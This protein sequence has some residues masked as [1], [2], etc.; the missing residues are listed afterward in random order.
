MTSFLNMFNTCLGL[1]MGLLY[2]Y[3]MIYV[4]IGLFQRRKPI[5]PSA[6][7]SAPLH[8]Y[9]V[10]IP[11]R[12]ERRVVPHLIDSLRRQDYPAELID[13]FV[14]ADNCTDD[15][16]KVARAAGA[17]VF[18]RQESTL[19]GKGY[20]LDYAMKEI[21]A[22]HDQGYDAF[23]VFDADNLV[24]HRFFT[25]INRTF[26]AGARIITSYRNSKNF[27][28]SWVSSASALWYLRESRFLNAV[29]RRLNSSCMISGTGFVVARDILERDNGW[30]YHL[31][32]EDI[33]FSIDSVIHGEKIVFCEEAMLYDE[34]PITFHQA[35]LQRLR[36]AKG[37]YQVFRHY[38]GA[39]AKR[40][41]SCPRKEKLSCFD[42]LMMILPAMLA[43]VLCLGM[44]LLAMIGGILISDASLLTAAARM[45]LTTFGNFYL[46]FVVYGLLTMITERNV[47][48]AT[49]Y[50][51]VRCLVLFPIY[52]FCH[53]PMSVQA[54]FCTVEWKPIAHTCAHT[55]SDFPGAASAPHAI[56]H[57]RSGDA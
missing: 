36:W 18:E 40:L 27:G 39:L 41:L 35:W 23:V 5:G 30:K 25:E 9:A 55:L 26:A 53:I 48:H 44:N 38:G 6:S 3:Q 54:L 34:Q 12:N 42:L 4:F 29:R 43:T 31:L 52:M 11:A 24:D 7:D 2:C 17:T 15:T 57:E 21:F 19:V 46:L 33:E 1:L 8:R 22:H 37:F 50:Q 14:I 20:A 16:A 28:S 32:T 47:F 51:K 45:L 49:W 10:L 13:I 56:P